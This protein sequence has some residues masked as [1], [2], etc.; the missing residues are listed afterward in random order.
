MAAAG[1]SVC[2]GERLYKAVFMLPSGDGGS[3]PAAP[4]SPARVVVKVVSQ[5][6]K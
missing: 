4:R 3:W 5:K 1:V 6:L 2:P